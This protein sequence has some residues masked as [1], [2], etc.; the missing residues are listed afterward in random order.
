M[1]KT[2][3]QGQ[4]GE[5]DDGEGEAK[6]KQHVP[7]RDVVNFYFTNFPSEWNKVNLHDLFAEVGEIANVY[8]A[9]K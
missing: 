9:K 8:V 1:S 6:R 3:E 2:G 7:R 5:Q 4:E